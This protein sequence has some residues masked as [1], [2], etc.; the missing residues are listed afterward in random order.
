[1]GLAPKT[2]EIDFFEVSYEHLT[3]MQYLEYK[4]AL[5]K[6]ARAE[7]ALAPT[8]TEPEEDDSLF[9]MDKS[10]LASNPVESYLQDL[11]KKFP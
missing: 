9:T 5:D 1:M 10:G 7:Q 4:K 8:T 6:Q 11:F 2:V 3:L